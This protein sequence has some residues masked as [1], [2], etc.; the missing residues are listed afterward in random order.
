MHPFV[1]SIEMM[2]FYVLGTVANKTHGYDFG[3]NIFLE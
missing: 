1:G 3:P 2:V